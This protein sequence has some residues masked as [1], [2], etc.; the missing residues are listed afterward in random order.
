MSRK[1]YISSAIKILEGFASLRIPVLAEFSEFDNNMKTLLSKLPV[2]LEVWGS[3]SKLLGTLVFKIQASASYK[4]IIRQ[5]KASQV[6]VV[7]MAVLV[8]FSA[9]LSPLAVLALPLLIL[10]LLMLYSV[11]NFLVNRYVVAPNRQVYGKYISK[12]YVKLKSLIDYL[13]E[14]AAKKY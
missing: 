9:L 7:V 12:E 8:S 10:A 13:K 1:S 5:I 6:S 14:I 2:W 11:K 3:L 4:K